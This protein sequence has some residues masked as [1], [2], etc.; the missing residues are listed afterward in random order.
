MHHL[1]TVSLHF[2]ASSQGCVDFQDSRHGLKLAVVA[3]GVRAMR[4]RDV[5]GVIFETVV[6]APQ[7]LAQ[8]V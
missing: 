3:S 2:Y 1:Q 6:R 4:Q 8:I 7:C 5:R